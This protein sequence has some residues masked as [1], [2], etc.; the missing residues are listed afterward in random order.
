MKKIIIGVLIGVALSIPAAA[1]ALKGVNSIYD[2]G[3]QPDNSVSVFDDAGN[4]CYVAKGR[5]T[6]SR[7][8]AGYGYSI[9]CVGKK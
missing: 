4:K 8:F 9:S 1:F 6:E 5:V 2:M 7:A 3:S